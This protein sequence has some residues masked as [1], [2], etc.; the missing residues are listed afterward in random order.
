MS[1]CSSS[2]PF[3]A[4]SSAVSE[5][6]GDSVD[7]LLALAFINEEKENFPPLPELIH[8]DC[9]SIDEVDPHWSHYQSQSVLAGLKCG[10]TH[11]PIIIPPGNYNL[12]PRKTVSYK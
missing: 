3:C 4:A 2:C 10:L 9:I 12:R 11:I 8:Q 5:D 7:T 6:S 1:I